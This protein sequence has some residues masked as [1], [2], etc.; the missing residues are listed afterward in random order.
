L[1]VILLIF[2]MAS[3]SWWLSFAFYAGLGRA[4]GT[5]TAGDVTCT[6]TTVS[7]NLLSNPSWENGLDGWS[8]LYPRSVST[9]EATD[10]SYSLYGYPSGV[11]PA[12][13]C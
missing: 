9:A 7:T 2:D 13:I 5:D 4:I 6:E 3:L 10:G 1:D 12:Q 8:Y 11:K